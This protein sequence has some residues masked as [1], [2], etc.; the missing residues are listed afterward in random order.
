MK[1]KKAI[2]ARYSSHNQDDGTSIEVQLDHCRRATGEACRE[3]I[4]RAVSG[5][6]MSREAFNCLIADCEAGLIDTLYIYKWD[7]FGRSARAHAVIADL[8]DMGVTVISSTEGRDPLG[9]GIQ[10]VVAEDFSRKL[11]ER[12]TE[13]KRRRFA[14]GRWNGG[15][16]LFGYL[17][18]GKRLAPDWSGQ[19]DVVVSIFETYLHDNIGFKQIARQL[20]ARGIKPR[21]AKHWTGGSIRTMLSNSTYAGRPCYNG[22]V[23][24]KKKHYS[25]FYQQGEDRLERQDETLRVVSDKVFDAAQAK[26]KGRKSLRP[27]GQNR[28]RK[29]SR[30]ITCG[31]CGATFIRRYKA[32]GEKYAAWSCG[33]R[34]RI[35]KQLC[36]NHHTLNEERLM[37]LIDATMQHVT[38]DTEAIVEEA[39]AE[40]R[41][42]AGA[43]RN[44]LRR[45]RDQI[46]AI[47]SDLNRLAQCLT[48]PDLSEPATKRLLS[49]QV[50]DKSEERERLETRQSELADDANDNTDRLADTVR[51]AVGEM[52]QSLA[53]VASD[54]ELNQFVRDF[55]GEMVVEADGSIRPKEATVPGAQMAE[56]IQ[57]RKLDRRL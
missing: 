27:M 5:T 47:D 12:V 19:A 9:R 37:A 15:T 46:A 38:Q 30:L 28:T 43:N 40:A 53:R 25:R 13:A 54:S 1:S 23:S 10:L 44:E 24:P 42:L 48:D 57:Y 56:A 22:K 18:E 2:Y 36:S 41:K 21:R 35:D 4:D 8:E 14:E 45:V 34:V 16:P 49:K 29:F 50:A 7:R 11:S 6:T 31:V 55:V 20:N 3:Y 52:K 51:Q 33:T 17:V 32:G 39:I 26:M